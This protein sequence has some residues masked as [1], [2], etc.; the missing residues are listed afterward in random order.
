MLANKGTSRLRAYP[1]LHPNLNVVRVGFLR[2]SA[3]YDAAVMLNASW[4]GPLL[5]NW[6]KK[7]V[8][9]D[10]LDHRTQGEPMVFLNGHLIEIVR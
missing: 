2:F 8:I 9:M 1:K 3:R 10:H 5:N 7:L 4:T 6:K